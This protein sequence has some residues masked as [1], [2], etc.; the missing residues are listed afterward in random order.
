MSKKIFCVLFVCVMM[1]AVNAVAYEPSKDAVQSQN[2]CGFHCDACKP[3]GGDVSKGV[4]WYEDEAAYLAGDGQPYLGKSNIPV[5]GIYLVK[6]ENDATG[7]TWVIEEGQGIFECACG[8]TE[9]VSY[10]NKNGVFDGKNVQLYGAGVPVEEFGWLEVGANVEQWFYLETHTPVYA[11]LGKND[12]I[13][14]QDGKPLANAKNNL[15]FHQ[16]KLEAA[17]GSFMLANGSKSTPI[18]VEINYA[19]ENGQVKLWFDGAKYANIVSG[20]IIAVV[21]D[22]EIGETAMNPGHVEI[23]DGKVVTARKWFSPNGDPTHKNSI[24]WLANTTTVTK[25]DPKNDKK[26]VTETVVVEK[27]ATVGC[28]L[29]VHIAGLTA[30]DLN[31]IIGC[32]FA[33]CALTTDGD[34]QNGNDLWY[35]VT[36]LDGEEVCDW[37]NCNEG[38]ISLP[39]GTY[40]VKYFH[41][42]GFDGEQEREV[43]ITTGEYEDVVFEDS[44]VNRDTCQLDCP[45][46]CGICKC[47]VDCDCLAFHADEE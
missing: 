15:H 40:I 12:T 9:W 41:G 26:T 32:E 45:R 36:T 28:W 23:G 29:F 8:C 1:M 7:R 14:L 20:G 4:T 3:G 19:I 5:V 10:S 34:I 25:P 44:E 31:D 6:D 46:D 42:D 22:K 47:P 18:G 35:C 27:D 17:E 24:F 33:S 30:L 21:S 43:S 39:V 13:V 38:P 2:K 37:A 16:I 11:G